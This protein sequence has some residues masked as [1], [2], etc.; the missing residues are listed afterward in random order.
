MFLPVSVR[1]FVIAMSFWRGGAWNK[2][3]RLDF[4]SDP[5]P[6]PPIIHPRNAF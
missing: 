6:L 2:D 1:L 4:G 3:S 5:K